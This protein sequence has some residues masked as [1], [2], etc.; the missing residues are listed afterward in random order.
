MIDTRGE[1]VPIS[2]K[3]HKK[4]HTDRIPKKRQGPVLAKGEEIRIVSGFDSMPHNP[5]SPLTRDAKIVGL[6]SKEIFLET[7][8]KFVRG[9]VVFVKDHPFKVQG[10]SF[11][12]SLVVLR[13]L[14]KKGREQLSPKPVDS[15]KSLAEGET[16]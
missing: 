16:L 7:A 5:E 2:A 9:E 14:P 10:M 15:V 11:D 6:G 12:G 4:Q 8:A 1:V 13:C 3:E